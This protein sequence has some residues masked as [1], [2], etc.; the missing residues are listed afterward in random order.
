MSR[1][2]ILLVDD[3]PVVRRGLRG[4]LSAVPDLEIVGEAQSGKE[5][6]DAVTVDPP[7]IVL[8]DIRMPGQDGIT[9]SRQIRRTAPQTRIII[10]TVHDDPEY[11]TRALEADVHGYLM[12]DSGST[13]VIEAIRKVMAGQR[14][15]AASLT[16][17]LLDDY[18][19]LSRER[20]LREADLSSEELAILEAMSVGMSYRDIGQKLHM[21]EITVR[22]RVQH[23]YRKLDVGDRAEA[24]AVAIRRG[25]I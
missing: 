3:H 13:E 10:L 6:I 4:M 1:T 9:V 14:V 21:G 23:A 17:N 8:L 7:D 2:R 19:R 5:A 22:R 12:K 25:L 15:V 16:A 11:V 24:V 18:V 20:T